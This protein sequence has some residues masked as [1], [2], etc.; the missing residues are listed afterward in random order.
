LFFRRS[1]QPFNSAPP[2]GAFS[3]KAG[4]HE[5]ASFAAIARRFN[6]LVRIDIS[7]L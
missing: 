5:F 4:D 3:D 1:N 2:R 6:Q 7:R